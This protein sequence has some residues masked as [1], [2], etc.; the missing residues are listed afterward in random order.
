MF[1]HIYKWLICRSV[2][3]LI[4]LRGFVSISM[5]FNRLEVSIRGQGVKQMVSKVAL[6][7]QYVA[8]FGEAVR[9]EYVL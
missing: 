6:V 9:A 1:I 5:Q 4:C 7:F 2:R 8:C 3:V